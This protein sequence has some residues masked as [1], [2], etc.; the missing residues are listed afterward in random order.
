MDATENMLDMPAVGEMFRGGGRDGM[1]K[2]RKKREIRQKRAEKAGDGA[3]RQRK[4]QISIFTSYL[5]RKLERH[6]P[7]AG[8][9]ARHQST[10][11]S[12]EVCASIFL[13]SALDQ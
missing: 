7:P 12:P 10:R 13:L 9:S 3:S 2:K 8:L 4:L 11:G 1:R 6:I 5:I